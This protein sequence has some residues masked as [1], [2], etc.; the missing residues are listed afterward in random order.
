MQKHQ[1]GSGFRQMTETARRGWSTSWLQLKQ[2]GSLRHE[3]VPEQTLLCLD[4]CSVS[5]KRECGLTNA[6]FQKGLLKPSC[7]WDKTLCSESRKCV[8]NIV[9][10]PLCLKWGGIRT[11]CGW[12]CSLKTLACFCHKQTTM[13]D[14]NRLL[15]CTKARLKASLD[16]SPWDDVLCHVGLLCLNCT[17]YA[18]D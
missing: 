6:A 4:S 12:S 14:L 11:M 8:L 1:S 18:F 10:L 9:M 3:Q 2:S 16:C 17:K 7:P 15:F 5:Q 13:S